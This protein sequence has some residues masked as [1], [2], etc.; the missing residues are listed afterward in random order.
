LA[1]GAD[2]STEGHQMTTR[3][4][5]LRIGLLLGALLSSLASILVLATPASADT[6]W[7]YYNAY[8]G[9]SRRLTHYDGVDKAKLGMGGSTWQVQQISN[10]PSGHTRVFLKTTTGNR[11]LDSHAGN[12]GNAVYVLSCNGGDYQIW[13]V[14]YPGNGTRVFKSW[15]SWTQQSRHLCMTSSSDPTVVNLATCNQNAAR[16]QWYGSQSG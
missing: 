16:Q 2:C 4:L 13:E 14:F 7:D 5:P 3:R 11:C 9:S 15:G 12:V 10:S 6:Y 1:F 8:L